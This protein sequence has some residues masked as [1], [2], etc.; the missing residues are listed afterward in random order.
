MHQYVSITNINIVGGTIAQEVQCL[1]YWLDDPRDGIT[2]STNVRTLRTTLHIFRWIPRVCVPVTAPVVAQSVGTGIA[3]PFYDHGT[4]SFEWS[5]ARPGRTGKDTVPIVQE[6]GRAPGPVCM[7]R[8][9]RPT[10]I[11]YPERPARSQTLYR[12]SYPGLSANITREKS[13][14]I[15]KI[16]NS[17]HLVLSLRAWS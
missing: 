5:A 8:K 17:F 13:N 2:L 4:R 1:R 14:V 3:L 12:L 16:F 11:R 10:G 9:S 7:G 15:V 6:A